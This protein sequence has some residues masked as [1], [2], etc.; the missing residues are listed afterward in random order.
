MRQ[1]FLA[2]ALLC[3]GAAHAQSMSST[4]GPLPAPIKLAVQ[5]GMRVENKFSAAGGL[6]GWILSAPGSNDFRV[7]FTPPGG[8]VLVAGIMRNGTGDDLTRQYIDR[9]APKHDLDTYWSRLG[10]VRYIAQGAQGS[11]VKSVIYAFMDPNCI[12]CHLAWE[13]FQPY[14]KVGLQVRW[15]PTG[16]QGGDSPAQAAAL[17]NAKDPSAAF[18]D[19]E[20]TWDPQHGHPGIQPMSQIPPAL[21]Q[22]LDTNSRLMVEMNIHGTPAFVYQDADGHARLLE[23][24]P[25]LAQIPLMTG[26][27]AQK[28]PEKNLQMFAQ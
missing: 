24:M 9:Y 19:H 14:M 23:G 27:P 4:L 17:L 11:A 1:L 13:A 22:A 5:G 12:Y 8:E 21:K 16:I 6:T 18:D 7:A 10:A 2:L 26:L 25:K 15:V 20:R 3:A 28:H